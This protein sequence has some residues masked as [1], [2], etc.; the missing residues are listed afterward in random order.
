MV[1][2]FDTEDGARIHPRQR[3]SGRHATGRLDSR[4][5][6]FGNLVISRCLPGHPCDKAVLEFIAQSRLAQAINRPAATT[7]PFF[8]ERCHLRS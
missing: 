6:A 3:M 8:Q 4:A 2:L 7:D 5:V 1:T